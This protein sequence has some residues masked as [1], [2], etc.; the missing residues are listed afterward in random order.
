MMLKLAWA[1]VR[2]SYKDFAIYFLTLMIGVAVYYAFNSIKDQQG[3][4]TLN[5]QQTSMIE[6]TG[7][8]IDWVSIF[9]LIILAFLVIYASRFLIKRRNKEFGMYL[10]LGMPRTTL[11]GLTASETL[12]VGALSLVVGLA[13]GVLLSQV[14]VLVTA[15][16]FAANMSEEFT[17][18]FSSDVVIKTVVVFLVIFALSLLINVGYLAK[19][20][21]IDLLNADRKNEVLTLR[22]IPLAFALF[23]VSVVLIGAAYKVLTDNGLTAIDGP[24]Q[25]ATL[26]VCV[27]TVLFFYSLSG[28]LLRVVQSIKPLYYRG[29]NMFVL[30]QVASRINSSFVSMS[31]ICM[32]LF[33]AITSVCGGIG[34]C[35][36]MTGAY[37]TQTS[38]DAT[39]RSYYSVEADSGN[40][41]E[42]PFAAT[43]ESHNYDMN[44]GLR[45]SADIVGA[46]KWDSMV[47]ESGQ[48]NYY[49]SDVTLADTDALLGKPLSDYSSAVGAYYQDQTL[50]VAKLS[51]YNR[52]LELAGKDPVSI[53]QG[54]A[55]IAY[56]FDTMTNYYKDLVAKGGTVSL[57]GKDFT[58]C[59]W[60][61]Q[62]TTETTSTAM[63]TGTLVINDDEFPAE[64][65]DMIWASLLNVQFV[66]EGALEPFEDTLTS[67]QGS[68]NTDTWPIAMWQTKQG[69]YDQG[70]SFSTIVSYLAI[71]IGF[72][73]VVACAAILAI[74][75]LTAA[76]DNRRRY[77]LLDKLGAS[78]KMING[79]LFK[80]IAIAFIFPMALAICHSICALLVVIDVVSIFGHIE[81]GEVAT[82]AAVAFFVVY[83]A[84]FLLTYFQARSV[85]RSER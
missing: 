32:T 57:Y 82:I 69:V 4:L 59:D 24:F 34:I 11:L 13:V 40:E 56:D 25:I 20:K 35:N 18:L 26:L 85:I 61:D 44:A 70:I 66:D 68:E 12:L 5:E 81:I 30:R 8:L 58:L 48:L 45:D 80:Q 6:V 50:S 7:M 15:L 71:Y 47:R 14:L 41:E 46:T 53:P 84:Y 39:I 16:L 76:S 52:A 65:N 17:F 67:I 62:T 42:F 54:Q 29:L 23:I 37:A 43:V 36:A 78:R 2:R 3:V 55:L 21:L 27:G 79:A 72:V 83:F 33:L 22:S 51:E 1:N 49:S 60:V 19:A 73:L 9:I 38:Y 10:L 63:Q 75:Q 31:V 74:Q 28:F 64:A 77:V